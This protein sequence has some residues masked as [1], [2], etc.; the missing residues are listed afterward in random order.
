M[1]IKKNTT[2]TLYEIY[3]SYTP[4][5]RRISFKLTL[6]QT[7]NFTVNTNIDALFLVHKYSTK[8]VCFE[9]I[10]L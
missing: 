1:Q 8:F 7:E 6:M 5:I 2:Q 3:F 10:Y 9:K 4:K